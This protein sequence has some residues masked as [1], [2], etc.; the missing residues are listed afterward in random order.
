[1]KVLLIDDHAIVR[2]GLRRL[3]AVHPHWQIIEA[4]TGRDAL[5]L[6]QAERPDLVVLD[7]NLPG[8]G[9]FELLRR[10]LREHPLAR[11]LVLSMHVQASFA[12][13][14]I[15]A[16][17]CGYMSKNAAPAEL[18]KAL[19][20]VAEGSR[21]IEAEI[22]QAVAL[23]PVAAPDPAHR[24]SERDLEIVRLLGAGRSLTE[25]AAAL[26]LGYKTVANSCTQIKAKLGVGRTA[27][28]I[29]L[30]AAAGEAKPFP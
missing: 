26:G 24:L 6:V 10:I 3:L 17:A 16:G 19:R 21:Y 13:R 23:Q 7:L 22:A 8:L 20:T 14:A 25:I 5:A 30:G 18:L 1:M 29:R 9:G 12:A 15:Q 27:D 11:V 28:L 4:A 2:S